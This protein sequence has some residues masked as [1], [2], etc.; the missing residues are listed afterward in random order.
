MVDWGLLPFLLSGVSFGLA[1]GLS[2]GPLMALVISQTLRYGLREGLK[3]T[4]APLASDAPIILLC[5]FVLS[6]IA[7]LGHALAWVSIFG[8]GFVDYLGYDSLRTSGLELGEKQ[9]APRSSPKA[10]LL[11]LPNPRV[12]LFWTTV[13]SAM[14]LRGLNGPEGSV[15][16][17]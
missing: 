12:C 17:H 5:L 1:A 7:D 2:P 14:I 15:A 4:F 6:R 13:G 8:G 9:T 10:V 16:A 11:N 3:V